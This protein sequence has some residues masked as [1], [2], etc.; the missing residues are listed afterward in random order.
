MPRRPPLYRCPRC[1]G[2]TAGFDRHQVCRRCGGELADETPRLAALRAR[3]VEARRQDAI[4][5]LEGRDPFP[6]GF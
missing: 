6:A 4:D 1:G 5:R 3:M 2:D